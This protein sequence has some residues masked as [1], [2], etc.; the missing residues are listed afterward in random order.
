VRNEA[1]QDQTCEVCDGK[2]IAPVSTEGYTKLCRLSEVLTFADVS[3][4]DPN[5]PGQRKSAERVLRGAASDRDKQAALGQMAAQ[6][7]T[8]RP[9]PHSGILLAGVV[10][11]SGQAG[12]Y[13]GTRLALFDLPQEVTVITLAPWPVK[14]QS[15]VLM[16]GAIID[17]PQRLQGY[18]G[19][20]GPVVFGG[21][22]LSLAE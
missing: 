16:A 9:R 5:V 3:P 4:D 21:L 11:S 14:P 22:P 12:S 10:R 18:T 20:A 7:L 6:L 19:P 2:P 13:H 15:R 17:E 1:G 8:V